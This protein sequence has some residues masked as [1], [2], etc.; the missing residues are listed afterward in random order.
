M[1]R[2]NWRYAVT[3]RRQKHGYY[4]NKN[5]NYRIIIIVIMIITAKREKHEQNRYAV[6]QPKC[7]KVKTVRADAR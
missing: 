6:T 4:D 7:W 3:K 1:E 5:N 2:R